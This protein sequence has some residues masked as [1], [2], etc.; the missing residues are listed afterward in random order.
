VRTVEELHMKLELAKNKH[1]LAGYAP[2]DAIVVS[3]ELQTEHR[4]DRDIAT[5]L[6][7]YV[8]VWLGMAA[9]QGCLIVVC[10]AIRYPQPGLFDLRMRRAVRTMQ[11]A[12][13]A[14]QT[15]RLDDC[16]V[17]SPLDPVPH[18]QARN[19]AHLPPVQTAATIH[20]ETIDLMYGHRQD[21][22]IPL[23]TLLPMLST[24][25]EKHAR[26]GMGNEDR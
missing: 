15:A 17:L 5:L 10:I 21:R 23:R 2:E 22:K 13:E 18:A 6:V 25:I 19:W 9:G 8:R 16:V 12:V 20:P 26:G 14:L 1:F 7:E 3:T 24:L 4:S 11:E